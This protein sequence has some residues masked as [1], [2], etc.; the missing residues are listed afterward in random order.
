MMILQRSESCAKDERKEL[1]RRREEEERGRFYR[2]APANAASD[3]TAS[4]CWQCQRPMV[5]PVSGLSGHSSPK[6]RQDSASYRNFSALPVLPVSVVVPELH[7][8]H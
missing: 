4:D 7:R 8:R 3:G 6:V 5:S 2:E 1:R